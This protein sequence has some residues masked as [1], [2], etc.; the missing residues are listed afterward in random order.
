MYIYIY[1]VFESS[2]EDIKWLCTTE[3]TKSNKRYLFFF[4]EKK[5]SSKTSLLITW[6]FIHK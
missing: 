5:K 6:D 3:S 2:G 1:I 4:S